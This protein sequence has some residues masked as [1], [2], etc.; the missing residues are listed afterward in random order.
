MTMTRPLDVV[1]TLY[2]ALANDD[3]SA[4]LA[5]LDP[6]IEWTEAEGFPLAGTYH[7][8]NAVMKEVLM[9]LATDWVDF[10]TVPVEFIDGGDAIVV[11]G[12]YSGTYKITGKSF[13]APFAHVWKIHNKRAVRYVQYTDTALVQRALQP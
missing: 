9:R 3:K 7:G 8:P 10:Q 5:G 11:L 2:K 13:R 6:R 1:Q 12:H 4:M